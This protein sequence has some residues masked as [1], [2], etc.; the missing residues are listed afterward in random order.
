[1]FAAQLTDRFSEIALLCQLDRDGPVTLAVFSLGQLD[2]SVD[3]VRLV[4]IR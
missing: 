4:W 1:V 3:S 2:L